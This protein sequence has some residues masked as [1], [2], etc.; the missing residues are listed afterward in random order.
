MKKAL[1]KEFHRE[2][3]GSMQRFVSILLISALGAAFF[4]GLRACKTDMLLS[5]DSFYD[6]TNMMDIRVVSALGLSDADV[7]AVRQTDGVLAAEGAFSADALVRHNDADVAVRLYSQTNQ[8]NTYLVSEGRMPENTSECAADQMFMERYGFQIGDTITLNSGTEASI[9]ETLVCNTVTI[10][11]S[12]VTGRYMSS[13]RGSGTIGN[14]K[15]AG[16]LVLAPEN[17]MMDYYAEMYVTLCG[18][19]ELN[20]YSDEYDTA[21]ES[22]KTAL[23]Q[24][25][26]VRA[27]WRLDEVKKDAYAELDTALDEVKANEQALLDG[28]KEILDGEQA[29]ADGFAEIAAAR[30]ELAEKR[31]A[32]P[33]MFTEYDEQIANAKQT[34][35]QAWTKLEKD[36]APVIAA[37]EEYESYVEQLKAISQGPDD[38]R[39]ILAVM[40][41]S[42]EKIIESEEKIAAARTE[43]EK[44]EEALAE[45]EKELEAQKKEAEDTLIAAEAELDENELTL[46][47]KQQELSEAKTEYYATLVENQNKIA[48]AYREI[49]EK[50]E[51]VA[52]L[53]APAWYIL[54]RNTIESYVG[55]EQDADRMDAISKVFPAI[56]FLVAALVSLTTMTRMVDEERTQIGT[57]KALG[58]GRRDV[59]GK[60]IKYALYAT[61][62]GSVIGVFAGGKIFPYIVITTYKLVYSCLPEVVMPLHVYYSVMAAV[63]A[64]LCTLIAT[65]AACLKAFHEQPAALM[66]PAAPKAGKRIFLEYI[67]FIWKHLSFTKKASLRNMFRYKKRFFMTVIGIG[68]CMALLLV[69]FGIKDSISVMSHIQY[70]ELWLYDGAVSLAAS[71]ES[72]EKESFLSQLSDRDEIAGAALAREASIDITANGTTKSVNIVVMPDAQAFG[73]YFV[74]RDRSSKKTSSIGEN[75]VIITEKLAKMLD[76]RAGDTIQLQPDN[77][78]F[79]PA[80]ISAVTENY[81]HHYIFM[82][83]HAYEQIFGEKPVYNECFL[84]FAQKGTAYEEA[85]AAGLLKD[86]DIVTSILVTSTLQ[87]QIDDML[88]SLNVITYVLIICAGMLAFIVLYNLSNINITERRRE[89][90]TLKVLGFYDGEV[91][92]Y[93]YRENVLLTLIGILLGIGLGKVLHGFVITTCEVDMVMFGHVIEPVSY[94]FSSLLTALFAVIVGIMMHFKLKKIDMI[95]SLKSIE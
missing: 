60:Y 77:T 30:G 1:R 23:E 9:S 63:L 65:L 35:S 7:E 17:F 67:G 57:L 38:I 28:E 40:G 79:Y 51:E 73:E 20:S 56:F 84:L 72:K 4:A 66:R 5:A 22:V 88:K 53:E 48:A 46:T 31:E 16:Y 82:T 44:Q 50:R 37:R 6:K 34:L 25:G 58:Y 32:L 24:V 94:L 78:T 62:L 19:K 83:E 95:E 59:A 75:E 69:G 92:G 47:Q 10:V 52:E 49:E 27:A 36:E 39:K 81:I 8:V 13:A 74:F 87:T 41:I 11:G 61:L 54:D 43:L 29:V 21:V 14:G 91:S 3:R 89:L 76:V 42:E 93:V 55:F 18:A 33:D 45:Q 86:F 71:A 80:K 26:D 90:A 2:I 70:G 85:A 68:G 64:V 15:I 12:V